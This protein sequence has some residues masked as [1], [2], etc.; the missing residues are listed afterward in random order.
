MH[1]VITFIG[2]D[3][4]DIF[5]KFKVLN[6]KSSKKKDTMQIFYTIQSHGYYENYYIKKTYDVVNEEQILLFDM[7]NLSAGGDD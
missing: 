4:R 5:I 6:K 2:K 1:N 3:C 7:S